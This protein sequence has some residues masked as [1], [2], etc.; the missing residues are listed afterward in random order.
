MRL[1]IAEDEV[2]L[3]KALAAILRKNNY[4]VDSV[5]DGIEALSFLESGSY[6]GA[7]RMAKICALSFWI[8]G[9]CFRTIAAFA[10]TAS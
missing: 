3:S 7:I 5:F 1:L 10:Q 9:A 4:E 8:T 6:D 2:F